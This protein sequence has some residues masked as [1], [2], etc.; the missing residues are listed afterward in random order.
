MERKA[1]MP[2]KRSTP[3]MRHQAGE[4]RHELTP[5]ENKLWAYLR[6]MRED[7]LHFRRQ[8]AIGQYIAD[9]CAPRNKL[10]VELDGSQHLA[11]EE[12][13]EERTRYLK[14]RGYRVIRFWNDEVM[15]NIEGVMVC[16]MNASEE[17]S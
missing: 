8:Y 7:G 4:L 5:A 1:G 15:N 2:T 9:F 6:S 17:V 13:D 10:V 11:Q 16:I 12:Y 14:A 3:T